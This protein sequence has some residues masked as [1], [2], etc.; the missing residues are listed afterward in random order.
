MGRGAG[1]RDKNAIYTGSI[2]TIR[3]RTLFFTEKSLFSYRVELN[4]D[5]TGEILRSLN[6]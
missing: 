5:L 1:G 3:L 2:Y 6:R 4:W